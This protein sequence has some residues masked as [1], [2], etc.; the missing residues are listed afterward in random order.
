M[1]E[2]GMWDFVESLGK[3]HVDDVNAV[4]VICGIRYE[5]QT[6]Q[7]LQNTR[8]PSQK[9]ELTS[10]EKIIFIHIVHHSLPDNNLHQLAHA[11]SEANRAKVSWAVQRAFLVDRSNNG[12]FPFIRD[13]TG[14]ENNLEQHPEIRSKQ[15]RAF[16]QDHIRDIIRSWGCTRPTAVNGSSYVL[17]RKDHV[18]QNSV[19]FTRTWR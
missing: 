7:Q 16:P 9:P 8:P 17:V 12:R 11:T 14:V 19:R 18:R 5:I 6:I 3:V 13:N 15:S 10:V 2:R 4:P 1:Q